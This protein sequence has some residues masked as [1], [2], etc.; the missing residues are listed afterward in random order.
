MR[1]S[2]RCT[3][4]NGGR[5]GITSKHRGITR[6]HMGITR[7]HR[8]ITRLHRGI[9]II[10]SS[11][12]RRRRRRIVDPIHAASEKGL[13]DSFVRCNNGFVRVRLCL[14]FSVMMIS[15]TGAS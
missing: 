6:I 14:C 2:R 10:Q 9:T 12:A 3:N 13:G 8:G 15:A 4:G 5:L 7:L 11:A 1:S